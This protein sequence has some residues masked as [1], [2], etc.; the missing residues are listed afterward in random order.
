M[1][2]NSI[3][4]RITSKL[5]EHIERQVGSEGLYESASEYIRDLIRRDFQNQET[6]WQWLADQLEPGLEADP[7]EFI[8]VSARDVIERNKQTS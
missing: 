7:K 2:S 3:N 6:A 4:I 5:R 1:A 8:K